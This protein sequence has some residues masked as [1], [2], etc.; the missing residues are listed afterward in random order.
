M[1]NRPFPREPFHEPFHEPFGIKRL[2]ERLV[3][4][5]VRNGRFFTSLYA[6]LLFGTDMN[7]I[8]FLLELGLGP[9]F[10]LEVVSTALQCYIP[11]SYA[12]DSG[13]R[14]CKDVLGSYDL[15]C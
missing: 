7:L 9:V 14:P 5:L 10:D 15:V 4:R 12:P 11:G 1:K 2:V 3:E 13:T 8:Y 6:S